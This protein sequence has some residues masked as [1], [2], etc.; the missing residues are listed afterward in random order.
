M[1]LRI[2]TTP[3]VGDGGVGNRKGPSAQVA[4]TGAG[5]KLVAMSQGYRMSGAGFWLI[6]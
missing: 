6:S 2:R 4:E 1:E 5:G 3:W